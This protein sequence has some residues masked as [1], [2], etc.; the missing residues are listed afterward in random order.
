M[1]Y[2]E[3]FGNAT[4]EQKQPPPLFACASVRMQRLEKELPAV[5]RLLLCLTPNKLLLRQQTHIWRSMFLKHKGCEHGVRS[6]VR[7]THTHTLI[8]LRQSVR[9][10][11]EPCKQTPLSSDKV[12]SS[13]LLQRTWRRE[14]SVTGFLVFWGN[15]VQIILAKLHLHRSC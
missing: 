11:G 12:H 5:I 2:W 10:P 8:L 4:S 7:H 9:R 13:F 15:S 14:Q 6:K 3:P 1:F